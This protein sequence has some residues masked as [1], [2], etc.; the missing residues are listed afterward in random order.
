[1]AY[2]SKHTEILAPE[3]WYNKTKDEYKKYWPHLNS[4]Y[5]L[6]FNRFVPRDRNDYW[7]LDLWA[8][9]WRM[10][11]QLKKI[12]PD[13]YVAC[14]CAKELLKNHP[15]RVKKVVCDLEKSWPFDDQSFDL[16][17]A[18]FLLEHIENIDHFF[19]EANRVLKDNWQLL[20]GHFLQR[21]LFTW[22]INGERFKI[23]Q[24][25]HTIEDLEEAAKMQWFRTWILLLR[26][27]CDTKTI[28]W[29][30]LVCEK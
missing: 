7:V 15:W 3:V 29:H 10:Y 4:F 30:L 1:M 20:I 14:D 23:Q 24:F 27:V 6:D 2:D 11:E 9:D 5:S 19:E 22:A 12:N 25:P 21:R 13:G 8:G 26:D 16:L 17:S 28:T 18:F